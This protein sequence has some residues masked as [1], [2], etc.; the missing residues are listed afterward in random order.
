MAVV[1]RATGKTVKRID[2]GGMAAAA[3]A[4][5]LSV[6]GPPVMTN[7]RLVLEDEQGVTIHGS[8]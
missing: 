7:G 3:A 2:L 4:Q 5:R 1:D 6:I 8:K